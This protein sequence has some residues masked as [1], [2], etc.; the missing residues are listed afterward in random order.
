MG[1]LC[2]EH[3]SQYGTFHPK[4][5]RQLSNFQALKEENWRAHLEDFRTALLECVY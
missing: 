3:G 1:K 5:G 4:V 2:C